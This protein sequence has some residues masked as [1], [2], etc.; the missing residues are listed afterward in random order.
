[1]GKQ[2]HYKNDEP[3]LPDS[4]VRITRT[5]AADSDLRIEFGLPQDAAITVIGQPI[6]ALNPA[7]NNSTL[8][9]ALLKHPWIQ[10][11]YFFALPQEVWD[12]VYNA[13]GKG[14]FDKDSVELER[15]AA[16]ICGDCSFNAGFRSGRAFSFPLLR[17]PRPKA[18]PD[19]TAPPS[20]VNVTNAKFDFALELLEARLR[21]IKAV[22]R[23]YAGWLLTSRQFLDEH[24]AIFS[25]WG[26]LVQRW[27]LSRLGILLP[28]GMP[29]PGDDPTTDPQW[30][31][32]ST[33]FEEFFTRWRLLGM[34]APYLPIPLMPL[35]AGAL[36]V[37]LFPQLI[38]A[39]G[40]FCLPDTYPILSRDELRNLLE[41]SLHGSAKP[42]HLAEWMEFI[43]K[44]NMVKTSIARFGRLFEFQHYYRVLHHRHARALRGKS[45]ILKKVLAGILDT[46]AKTIT[47]DLGLVRQRL[48][49]DWLDRGRSLPMGPF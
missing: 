1:M 42:A 49:K 12:Q 14:A 43:A 21:P 10:D 33:A 16:T 41:G 47:G 29:I 19:E 5:L 30:P 11:R 48:G 9:A 32:Y 31:D 22:S 35:M 37:T 8:A 39:G 44:D 17:S 40:V 20:D 3:Q 24:D 25:Q 15:A 2:P 38:R 26:G 27:G 36:P 13:F 4:V 28:K 45:A 18:A 46:S 7:T 6:L 34:A 23:G